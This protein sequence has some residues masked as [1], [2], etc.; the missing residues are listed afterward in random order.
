MSQPTI[1]L[2]QVATALL[3]DARLEVVK[4]RVYETPNCWADAS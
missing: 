4:V 3:G 1:V 2:L